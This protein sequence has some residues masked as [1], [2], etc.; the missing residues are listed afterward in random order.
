MLARLPRPAARRFQSEPA[1]EKNAVSWNPVS[2]EIPIRLRHERIATSLQDLTRVKG[3]LDGAVRLRCKVVVRFAA[4]PG[5]IV[6]D[7]IANAAS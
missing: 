7:R 6:P 4:H 3:N 1:G 2:C 5:V